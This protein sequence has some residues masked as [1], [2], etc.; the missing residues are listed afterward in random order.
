MHTIYGDGGSDA[1]VKVA[2]AYPPARAMST[3]LFDALKKREPV[4]SGAVKEGTLFAE[5]W[6][7]RR[8]TR[9]L[10]G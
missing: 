6:W 2:L 5:A 1:E 4:F 8:S 3:D 9:H 10:T 7:G